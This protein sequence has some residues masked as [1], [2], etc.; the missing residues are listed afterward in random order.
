MSKD[1][2][3]LFAFVAIRDG[4]EGTYVSYFE[5]PGDAIAAFIS[6]EMEYSEF[7]PWNSDLFYWTGVLPVGSA[8]MVPVVKRLASGHLD[9]CLDVQNSGHPDVCRDGNNLH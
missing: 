6:A 5:H 2:S 7:G 9:V 1:Y 8:H 3:P 4:D